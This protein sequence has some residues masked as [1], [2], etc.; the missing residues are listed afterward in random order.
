MVRKTAKAKAL[1]DSANDQIAALEAIIKAIDERVAGKVA[2]DIQEYEIASD[3]GR[4][5][6]A[7]IPL[8][9]LMS[10]RE[11]YKHELNILKDELKRMEKK[12]SRNVL[13]RFP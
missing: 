5:Q 7:K 10:A 6:V 9:D 8:K 11:T 1:L 4:R 2:A 13:V 12:S 3:I